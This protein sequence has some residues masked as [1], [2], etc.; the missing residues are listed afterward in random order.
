MQWKLATDHISVL[1]ESPIWDHRLKIIHWVDISSGVIHSLDPDS[2]KHQQF[3]TGEYT[4][5]VALTESGKLLAA[6]GRDIELIDTRNNANAR[7]TIAS[8][9]PGFED[10][11]F[12]DG[13]CDP[14]GRLW[15]GTMARSG[16]KGAG[17]LYMISADGDVQTKKKHISCSNGMGWSADRKT[18]YY[19]DTPTKKI[20]AFDF[21][22]AT[23]DISN[24]RVAVSLKNEDGFP[25]GM[26]VDAEGMI[27]VAMWGGGC[28]KRYDPKTGEKLLQIA[29]PAA[30]ITSCCFGGDN[31]TDLYI[32]SAREGVSENVLAEQP[33]AGSLFV[34]KNCGYKGGMSIPFPG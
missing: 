14:A 19:I 34:I 31:L 17:S 15:V 4:G 10:N 33:L 29:M 16:T 5:M 20:S 3:G 30:N 13:K 1:G 24:E 27:W 22:N 26:C 18:M 7:K 9:E 23:G 2:G 25:D 11:R 8:V 28:V 12:N 6:V 32:T 21:D